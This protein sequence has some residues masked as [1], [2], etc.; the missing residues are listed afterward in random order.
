[1]TERAADLRRALRLSAL[2]I[3]W[4]GVAGSIAIY[5]ALATGSLSLLGFGADAVIDSIASVVL[6]W[7]FLVESRQPSARIASSARPSAWSGWR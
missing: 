7:R 4:S 3:V 2:S 1:M 5:A 6:V